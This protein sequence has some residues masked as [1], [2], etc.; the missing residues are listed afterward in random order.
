[1]SIAGFGASPASAAGAT[2]ATGA[3]QHVTGAAQPKTLSGGSV[4]KTQRITLHLTA[5]PNYAVTCYAYIGGPYETGTAVDGYQMYVV[6][7]TT[8]TP[9]V[10][11]LHMT[12]YLYWNGEPM[13]A[14]S[15]TGTSYV[16][17]TVTGP[18]IAGTWYGELELSIVWP[19]GVTGPPTYT[20]QTNTVVIDSC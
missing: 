18:C 2:G 13:R 9:A 16:T 5:S 19:A 12:V 8:C 15:A 7:S 10:L 6:G 17:S 1:L 3:A 14:G 11:Y 4:E 20:T